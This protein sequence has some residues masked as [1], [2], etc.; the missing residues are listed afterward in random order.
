MSGTQK[1]PT[2][3]DPAWGQRLT[4]MLPR[5]QAVID[6]EHPGPFLAVVL[7]EDGR[8]E[9]ERAEKV[10]DEVG[11]AGQCV[12]Q[13]DSWK[14]YP[15]GYGPLAVK[16]G[17]FLP[18][19]KKETGYAVD[20]QGR[21]TWPPGDPAPD[22]TAPLKTGMWPCY[23]QLAGYAAALVPHHCLY[24]TESVTTPGV[25][26]PISP[27][28]RPADLWSAFVFRV[29]SRAPGHLQRQDILDGEATLLWYRG[30]AFTAN[31][32]AIDLLMQEPA[33]DGDFVPVGQLA[34][35]WESRFS[36]Y[37]TFLAALEKSGV[38]NQ[39]PQTKAG[40]ENPHRRLVHIGDLIAWLR[41]RPK[42]F[43][44][45]IDIDNLPGGGGGTPYQSARRQVQDTGRDPKQE[46]QARADGLTPPLSHHFPDAL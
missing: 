23:L 11:R 4:P 3:Y 28:A 6:P 44:K 22:R 38:R 41:N 9:A 8:H 25:H 39:R 13:P 29:L 32:C 18:D 20:F 46:G 10:W 21:A 15:K 26:F 27:H 31:A 30:D 34:G 12:M 35:L 24:S 17:G 2:S 45:G 40:K 33:T 37:K 7:F 5:F 16:W 19:G 1:K 14:V 42:T 43:V 36:S